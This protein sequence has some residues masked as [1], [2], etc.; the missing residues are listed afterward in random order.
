MILNYFFCLNY[1]CLLNIKTLATKLTPAIK[2][3]AIVFKK[4]T[5][6]FAYSVIHDNMPLIKLQMILELEK[7]LSL[8]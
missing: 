8:I 4:F 6:A 1:F 2:D 5:K 7:K 3:T